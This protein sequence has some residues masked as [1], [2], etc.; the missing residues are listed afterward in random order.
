MTLSA[1]DEVIWL[2]NPKQTGWRFLS[3]IPAELPY[4]E[5]EREME[6]VYVQQTRIV[7]AYEVQKKEERSPS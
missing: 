4:I 3:H 2:K 7:P 6:T 5:I 1:G